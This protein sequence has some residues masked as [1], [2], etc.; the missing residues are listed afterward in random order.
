MAKKK[1]KGPGPQLTPADYIRQKSRNLPIY[2][3]WIN[4]DWKEKKIANVLIGRKHVNG[5]LTV[6]VYLV[7]IACLGVKDTTCL[8]N[9]PLER[10]EEEIRNGSNNFI[11]EEAPY[12]LAHNIIY[13]ALEYAE[14]LGFKPHRD[15]TTLTQFFL[16]EDTDD[17]PLIEVVCGGRNGRP[18]YANTGHDNVALER[19]VIAQLEKAVGEGNYDYVLPGSSDY[20]EEDARDVS[21]YKDDADDE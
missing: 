2:K 12:E 3:C 11:L 1:K 10:C 9:N 6:C 14:D 8:F 15:F 4:S 19:M 20:Y 17:I 5:N 18:M 7:D 21:A 13:A 16:A